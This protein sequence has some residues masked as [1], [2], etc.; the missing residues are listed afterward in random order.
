MDAIKTVAAISKQ[1]RKSCGSKLKRDLGSK[2]NRQI[3]TH[4][5]THTHTLSVVVINKMISQ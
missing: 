2:K 3:N 4:T 5:H 1:T